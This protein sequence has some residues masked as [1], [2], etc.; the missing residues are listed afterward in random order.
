MLAHARRFESTNRVDGLVEFLRRW[1]GKDEQTAGELR[2]AVSEVGNI[3]RHGSPETNES[4]LL[5]RWHP[6]FAD[7]IEA[8]V[9]ELVLRLVTEWGC[10]TYSSCDGHRS[11]AGVPA[12]MRYVRLISTTRAAHLRLQ[13]ML[14]ELV[15]LTNADVEDHGVLL[16][17]KHSTVMSDDG[18]EAPG[19]DLIFEPQSADEQRYWELLGPI[20]QT[21]L[22]HIGEVSGASRREGGS[23]PAKAPGL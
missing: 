3:N 21:C 9:R 16:T 5:T 8:G 7:S 2:F 14:A 11:I 19:L 17:W 15:E 1:E 10:V 18:L 22:R 13:G 12:R 4:L 23:E 20:Y 6:S